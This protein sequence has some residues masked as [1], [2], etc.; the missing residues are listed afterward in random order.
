MLIALDLLGMSCFVSILKAVV[1][2]SSSG[3][4]GYVCPISINMIRSLTAILAFT[5][6][7]AIS[8]SYVELITLRKMLALICIRVLIK[9]RCRANG[10]VKSGLLPRKW[11]PPTRLLPP[12]TDKY[13]ESEDIHKTISD[14][15]NMIDR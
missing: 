6:K 15:L 11:Y 2:F 13:E 9:V 14:A 7:L 4:L 12:V 1:L 3:V 10:L 8:D 5:Y